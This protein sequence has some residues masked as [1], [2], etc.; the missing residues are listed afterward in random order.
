MSP[1]SDSDVVAAF[2]ATGPGWRTRINAALADWLKTH[3]PDELPVW[4]VPKGEQHKAI[5]D[6]RKMFDAAYLDVWERNAELWLCA[7]FRCGSMHPV[8]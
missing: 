2:R 4:A 1:F 5:D 6:G 7:W 8:A 3:S